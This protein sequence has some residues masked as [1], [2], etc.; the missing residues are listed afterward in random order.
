MPNSTHQ[1][2]LARYPFRRLLNMKIGTRSRC[3]S[4]IA[5]LTPK[6]QILV[7]NLQPLLPDRNEREVVLGFRNST[8]MPP[9]SDFP[10]P[11]PPRLSQSLSIR[12]LEPQH[13][14]RETRTHPSTTQSI[15]LLPP[16]SASLSHPLLF[17]II[18]FPIT[19]SLLHHQIYSRFVNTY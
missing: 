2:T 15:L 9:D 16:T 3:N 18:L 12:S 17:V 7:T 11:E 5:I 8:F 14:T 4:D 13:S 19:S 6:I 10:S 1:N